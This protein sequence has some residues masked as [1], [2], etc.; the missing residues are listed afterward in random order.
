LEEGR[1]KGVEGYASQPGEDQTILADT[2]S[3]ADHWYENIIR[4]MFG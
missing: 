1:I 3:A 4:Q 2:A